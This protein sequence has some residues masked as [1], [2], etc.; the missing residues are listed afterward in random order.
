MPDTDLHGDRRLPDTHKLTG[1]VACFVGNGL[2]S[3]RRR[4][5]AGAGFGAV[6]GAELAPLRRPH[7]SGA[8]FQALAGD[9]VATRVT[10]KD[11]KADLIETLWLYNVINM[12]SCVRCGSIREAS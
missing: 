8:R 12:V 7:P 3:E 5:P 10:M 4:R 9:P 1:L 11:M 6:S 2:A